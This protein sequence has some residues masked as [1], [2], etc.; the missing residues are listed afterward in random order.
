M[1]RITATLAFLACALSLPLAAQASVEW[2]VK[3]EGRVISADS[4]MIR[5]R[6][7]QNQIIDVVRHSV[8]DGFDLTPGKMI[9]W[10]APEFKE[11]K[12]SSSP[13]AAA[14]TPGAAPA[15][16]SPK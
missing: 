9:R 13:E 6:T 11:R 3:L 8:P 14:S 16:K 10:I 5:I 2:K 1:T 7:P 15:P 4:R 12:P